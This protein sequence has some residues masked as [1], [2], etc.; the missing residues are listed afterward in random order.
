MTAFFGFYWCF[1]A[2]SRQEFTDLPKYST[3]MNMANMTSPMRL[4]LKAVNYS[5]DS[6]HLFAGEPIR[7]KSHHS[8]SGN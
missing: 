6:R 1:F 5:S 7:L 2:H 4:V 8:R 3:L